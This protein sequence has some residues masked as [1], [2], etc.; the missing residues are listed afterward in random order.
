ME[1]YFCGKLTL[2]QVNESVRLCGWVHRLR[3]LGGVIF[4][5]LRDRSGLVQVV[6][7][8]DDAEE[9]SRLHNEDVVEI[10]GKVSARPPDQ[11]DDRLTSGAVE[12]K[13]QK[14][15]VLNKT[16]ELPFS[17][18]REELLPAEE[19]RLKYRYLDLRRPVMTAHL[20]LRH[21]M[22]QLGRNYL[23]EK[24][25]WEIETPLLAKSTPEGARDFLVA[26]RNMKGKFYALPQSPQLYK[27]ILMVSGIDKYFQWGRC[28]RDEDLRADRQPEHTQ[29]DIEASFVE[30]KDIQ[31]L[32]EGLFHLWAKESKGIYLD[33]PFP[34]M[35]YDEAIQRF[36][37]DK[38]DLRNPLELQTVTDRF[39]NSEFK[40][41]ASIVAK[42][43]VVRFLK[44]AGGAAWSRKDIDSL[45]DEVK[46][47]GFPGLAWVKRTGEQMSGPLSKFMNINELQDGCLCLGLAGTN[48]ANLDKAMGKL[49]QLCGKK[50]EL[51]NEND[52]KPVWITDFPLFE[53]DEDSGKIVP[54][55]HIFT[56]PQKQHLEF[57]DSD[58]LKVKGRLFD[59]VLNGVELGS[60]SVRCH[61]RD[62]QEKLLR[63]AGIDPV[64]FD[65]FLNALDSGAPPHAGIGMGFDRIVAVFAGLESIR[66]VIAFPKTTS[67]QGL[68][69]GQPAEVSEFQLKEL[70]IKIQKPNE[71]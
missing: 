3:N 57:L 37:S 36:G 28:L 6:I 47:F 14:I 68:M 16:K 43:G 40:I 41:F 38:P 55:H 10:I 31:T 26:S 65:F 25:Y 24:G 46:T 59:M 34:R 23:S 51:I 52:M 56:M 62:L 42:D 50:M 9:A 39:R 66:D 58:P 5:H 32:V 69:E 19:T 7:D 61:L 11:K 13:A 21:R 30:E 33:I 70:G 4:I 22:M 64:H 17:V 71:K 54:A 29:V 48:I 18:E 15:V 8:P 49:R 27:Q 35:T 45:A 53:E 1:R 63:I 60:G 12:I 2:E 20:R 67:G 44:L